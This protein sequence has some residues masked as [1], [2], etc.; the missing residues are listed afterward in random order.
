MEHGASALQP[1]SG[2]DLAADSFWSLLQARPIGRQRGL[3]E[4]YSAKEAVEVSELNLPV[5]A[6]WQR[7]AS[8]QIQRTAGCLGII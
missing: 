4:F 1:A 6:I 8:P 2:N 7:S 5:L 3:T